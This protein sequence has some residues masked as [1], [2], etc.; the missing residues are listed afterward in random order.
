[1]TVDPRDYD[2]TINA[3]DIKVGT[4]RALTNRF[5]EIIYLREIAMMSEQSLINTLKLYNHYPGAIV[6]D[7]KRG[8]GLRN[9]KLGT[10]WAHMPPSKHP[11]VRNPAQMLAHKAKG[12]LIR[13]NPRKKRR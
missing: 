6:K 10:S 12:K 4:D 5:G 8:L 13:R 9:I 1:M 3:I 2:L 11:I 7:L